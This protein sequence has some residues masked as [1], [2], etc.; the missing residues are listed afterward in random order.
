MPERVVDSTFPPELDAYID[1]SEKLGEGGFAEVHLAEHRPTGM[2]VAIKIMSKANLKSMGDLH[3]AYREIDAMKRLGS[4]QHVC[5]LYQVVENDE[6]IYLVLEHISGGELFD[7]IVSREKLSEK[8]S[9][10]FFRQI[11]SA[12]AYIHSKG[13]AH[14]DLKPENMLLDGN[15]SIKII[16]F[17]LASDPDTSLMMPLAT[18]CGSPAYAAPE[19]ISGKNYFGAEADIWSLGVVLYGL[20]NGFLPFDIEE[21]E[22]TYLLYDKIKLG[23]F[24]VPDWLSQGSLKM[25]TRLLTVNPEARVTTKDLLAHPWLSEGYGNPVEYKS[26]LSK[27]KL[28]PRIVEELAD[29]YHSENDGSMSQLVKEFQYDSLTAHYFL[30]YKLRQKT[31]RPKVTFKTPVRPKTTSKIQKENQP[32]KR[33]CYSVSIDDID[34]TPTREYRSKSCSNDQDLDDM[35]YIDPSEKEYISPLRDTREKASSHVDNLN[36]LIS[37]TPARPKPNFHNKRIGGMAAGLVTPKFAKRIGKRVANLMTP[38][39]NQVGEEPRK[40]KALY[41][42]STTSTKPAM[43]VRQEVETALM[44]LRATDRLTSY[45][46][47]QYLFKCKGRD[48]RGG[49]LIFQLEI[50]SVPGLQTIVGIRHTRLRGDAWSYKKTCD[51]ILGMVKI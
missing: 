49:K 1:L 45:E 13:L 20:L 4:H 9:R 35:P 40:V 15:N 11:V 31:P 38:R 50:C 21:D 42:C 6:N 48:E 27:E 25:L 47:S 8:E 36:K 28:E 22:P 23:E 51:I 3:R 30:L 5:Q 19:L 16:D 43:E 44:K 26:P 37:L 34:V 14:R 17:G 7:Y 39:K 46:V 12:V 33:N 41:K 32:P 2:K 10:S 18:C 29:Y 24:E